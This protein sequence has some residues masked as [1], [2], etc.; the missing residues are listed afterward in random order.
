MTSV[1]L[2]NASGP[3]DGIS[4]ATE[5]YARALVDLGARV[6]WYQCLDHG[7]PWNRELPVPLHRVHGFGLPNTTLDMG[8]NR[9]WTF[10]RRLRSL[11]EEVTFVTDPTLADVA[12]H[13]PHAIVNVHDLRPLTKYADRRL[14]RWAFRRAVPH[15]RF[16]HRVL[17]PSESVR[18]ELTSAGVAPEMIHVVPEISL[19]GSHPEHLERSFQ[20]VRASGVLRVL[21]VGTDRPYKNLSLLVRLAQRFAAQDAPPKLEFTIVSKL[22]RS[23]ARWV[24]SLHL[25]NLRVVSQLPSLAAAYDDHDVLVQPSLYEGFGRP[26][27]EAMGFGLPILA[28]QLPVMGEVVGDGGFLLPPEPLERWV[29]ALASLR[30]PATLATWARRSY[31]RSDRYSPER[32]RQ[33]VATAVLGG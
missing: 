27:V 25:G 1:A 17:V 19:L 14:T 31:A 13:H 4:F 3:T 18:R 6:A 12:Q 10:P 28:T 22:R 5:S 24:E 33:T 21:S 29:D 26:L 23:T 9:L 32:F 2:V 30:D 8:V 20:R 15:L 16:A 7:R 11:T